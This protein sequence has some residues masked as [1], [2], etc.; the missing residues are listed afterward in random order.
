MNG[1]FTQPAHWQH[2]TIS[3]SKYPEL[4]LQ[5]LPR[6]APAIAVAFSTQQVGSDGKEKVRRGEDWRRSGHNSTCIMH[7]QPF[8]H[9]P[10]HFAA[11]A[12]HTHQHFPTQP[13][14]IWG[15]DPDGAYRQ[16]PLD[17]PQRAYVLLHTPEGP[18]LWSHN[19]LLFGSS[20]S[21]WGYNRFGTPWSLCRGLSS[22]APP[23]TTSMTMAAQITT[24][25]IQSLAIALSSIMAFK[26]PFCCFPRMLAMDQ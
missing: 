20:V 18:T 11:L 4:Q 8:H 1:P 22:S 14:Q 17:Q 10:D 6:P 12:I 26:T 21:V 25:C 2:Q 9:T 24:F 19:V 3:P 23:C 7:D 5:P 13:L 15:H 16:L